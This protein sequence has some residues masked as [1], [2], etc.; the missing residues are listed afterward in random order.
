VTDQGRVYRWPRYTDPRQVVFTNS[1]L[2]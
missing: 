2:F 1:L